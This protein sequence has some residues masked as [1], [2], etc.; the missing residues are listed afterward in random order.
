MLEKKHYAHR[1]VFLGEST[2]M[3]IEVKSGEQVLCPWC[4]RC[5]NVRCVAYREKTDLVVADKPLKVNVAM[6]VAG[7]KAVIIGKIALEASPGEYDEIESEEEEE[8]NE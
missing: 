6:C 1:T 4:D 7:P 2:G 5:C 3:V 8:G